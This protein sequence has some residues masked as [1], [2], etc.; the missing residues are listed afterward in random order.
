MFFLIQQCSSQLVAAVLSYS[1]TAESPHLRSYGADHEM[2]GTVGER[3]SSCTKA[4][5]KMKFPVPLCDPLPAIPEMTVSVNLA[6]HD[7]S[8]LSERYRIRREL[9]TMSFI[10]ELRSHWISRELV[11]VGVLFMKSN[12]SIATCK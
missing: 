7:R 5:Q 4:G 3:S 8:S 10:L 2:G 12:H 11:Q 6:G 1:G 9:L